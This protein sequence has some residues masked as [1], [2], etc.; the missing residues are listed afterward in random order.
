V[1]RK[2]EPKAGSAPS[3]CDGAPREE[4]GPCIEYL[5]RAVAQLLMKNEK[6][7]FELFAVR[8]KIASIETAVFGAGSHDLRMGL[9]SFLLSALSDLCSEEKPGD[10]QPAARRTMADKMMAIRRN[11]R[12]IGWIRQAN[13]SVDRGR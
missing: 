9:P 12:P 1:N 6:M 10:Q 13:D 4:N 7:R 3:P 5:Q 2:Q 8:R 11:G